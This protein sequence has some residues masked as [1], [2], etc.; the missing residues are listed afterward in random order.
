MLCRWRVLLAILCLSI[1]LLLI[2]NQ[3]DFGNALVQR[4]KEENGFYPWVEGNRQMQYSLVSA[5]IGICQGAIVIQ[6]RGCLTLPE[7]AREA[8]IGKVTFRQSGKIHRTLTSWLW[9]VGLRVLHLTYKPKT[10][11]STSPT[12]VNHLCS[13]CPCFIVSLKWFHSPRGGKNLERETKVVIATSSH[14]LSALCVWPQ[15]SWHLKHI[16]L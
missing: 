15:G 7:L 1:Q 4:Q 13:P 14:F 3:L 2:E 10:P 11:K 5:A 9:Q 16:G 6:K 8:F 12:S